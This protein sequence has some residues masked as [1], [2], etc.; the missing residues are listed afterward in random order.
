[1]SY[2]SRRKGKDIFTAA[3]GIAKGQKKLVVDQN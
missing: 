3:S 2:R 1:M